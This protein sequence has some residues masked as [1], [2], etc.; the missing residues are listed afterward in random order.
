MLR[1]G[2]GSLLINIVRFDLEEEEHHRHEKLEFQDYPRPPR[3]ALVFTIR[4]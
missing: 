1:S 2:R 4:F 3:K